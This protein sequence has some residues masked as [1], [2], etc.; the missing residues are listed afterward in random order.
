MTDLIGDANKMVRLTGRLVEGNWTEEKPTVPGWYWLRQKRRLSV[1]RVLFYD[2][3][4]DLRRGLVFRIGRLSGASL[5]RVRGE[6]S[7]PIPQP[8]DAPA[9]YYKAEDVEAFLDGIV[10]V[11][12]GKRLGYESSRIGCVGNG[13]NPECWDMR[14]EACNSILS[15]LAALRKEQG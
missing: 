7:G 9:H 6:W 8:S 13:E 12:V 5:N 3:P 11:I 15:A 2:S 1:V 10:K 4:R 14:I